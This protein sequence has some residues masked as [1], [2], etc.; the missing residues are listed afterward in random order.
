M[1]Y[2]ENHLATHLLTDKNTTKATSVLNMNPLPFEP[3][4]LELHVYHLK[5]MS[6]DWNIYVK[7]IYV[8]NT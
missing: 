8:G 2:K 6:G 1:L 5:K 3:F 4:H 7:H